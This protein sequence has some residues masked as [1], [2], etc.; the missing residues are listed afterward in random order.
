M[1]ESENLR[2]NLRVCERLHI[3]TVL[4][5]YERDVAETAKALG[6]SRSTLY[7]KITDLR[8]NL[9]EMRRKGG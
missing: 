6:I 9:R 4:E 1:V 3:T 2:V 8:I 5:R 7:R